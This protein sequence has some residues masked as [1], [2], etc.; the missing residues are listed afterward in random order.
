M[1]ICNIRFNVNYLLK[2]LIKNY[3]LNKCG[4]FLRDKI[5][6]IDCNFYKKF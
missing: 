2:Y 4:N 1:K 6:K 5:I 3:K